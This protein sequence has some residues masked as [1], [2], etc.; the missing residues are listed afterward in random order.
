MEEI[1]VSQ[2]MFV[3]CDKKFLRMDSLLN[4]KSFDRAA[5][6][7]GLFETISS[8]ETF[9]KLPKPLNDSKK[10]IHSKFIRNVS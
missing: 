5:S 3:F 6:A 8:E 9:T 10:Q 2:K 1:P 7:N 4:K